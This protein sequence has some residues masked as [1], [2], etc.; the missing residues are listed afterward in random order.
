[1]EKIICFCIL[2][3]LLLGC[4]KQA[5]DL[6]LNQENTQMDTNDSQQ[7]ELYEEP[8]IRDGNRDGMFETIGKLNTF[9]E[10]VVKLPGVFAASHTGGTSIYKDGFLKTVKPLYEKGMG[11]Y[12]YPDISSDGKYI[13]GTPSESYGYIFVYSTAD[14]SL[15]KRIKTPKFATKP[16]WHPD[17]KKIIYIGGEFHEGKTENY[18]EDD[19]KYRRSRYIY[20]YMILKKARIRKYIHCLHQW[21]K[22]IFLE[23]KT[24]LY[25][26]HIIFLIYPL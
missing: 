22:K 24:Q 26:K 14:G 19:G 25:R 21:L 4:G 15:L 10:A 6:L 5:E 11:L 20:I 2:F 9:Y 3:V 17:G 1:M 18:W 12:Y 16:K 23:G 7:E 13:I 8:D